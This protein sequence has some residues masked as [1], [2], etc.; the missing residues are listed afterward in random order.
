[1]KTVYDIIIIG[2]GPAGMTALLYALRSRMNTLLIDKAGFGGQAMIIDRID[3]FPSFHEKSSGY[4]WVTAM[5]KQ[6]ETLGPS[7]IRGA[8]TG[9]K[10]CGHWSVITDDGS[11]YDSHAVIIAVGAYP[12]KLG[13]PGEDAFIGKGVSYC[14]TCDGPFFKQKDIVVIGGG[15]TAVKE[16]LFLTKFAKTLTLIHRRDR[17]RAEKMLQEKLL[18]MPNITVRW[19]SVVTEIH[20]EHLVTGVRVKNIKEHAE[21]MIA[22]QGVFVFAGITPGTAFAQELVERDDQGFIKTNSSLETKQP[23]IFAAG[24]C[25]CQLLRQIV[26]A[27]GDGATAAYAAQ[28]YVDEK[29]GSRYA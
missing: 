19:N 21:H 2:G 25:R 13:V 14:A 28:H 23:G 22:C 12:Q 8:V 3:N 27:C 24:D 17:L 6:L 16:S 18:H 10:N 11:S 9:L 4:E 5:E 29:R 7:V 20:G 1:M 15:D 26:T